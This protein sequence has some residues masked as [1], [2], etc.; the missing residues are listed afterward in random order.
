[1]R[2][3]AEWGT[4]RLAKMCCFIAYICASLQKYLGGLL[5]FALFDMLN[6][7]N[8]IQAHQKCGM[9]DIHSAGNRKSAAVSAG[10]LY[11]YK[12]REKP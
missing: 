10:S 7:K 12:R 3:S 11:K 6:V 9:P 1:M 8:G 4:N 2:R 5:F